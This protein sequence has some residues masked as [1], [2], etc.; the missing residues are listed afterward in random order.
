M[1]DWEACMTTIVIEKKFC[2]PPSSGNG[3][4]VAGVLAKTF[5]GHVSA[6]LRAPVPLGKPMSFSAQGGVATLKDGDTLIGDVAPAARDHLPAPPAAPTLEQARAAAARCGGSFHPICLTC[7]SKLSASEGLRVFVSQCAGAP[8]GQVAGL[9]NTHP[10]F[11]APDGLIAEEFVWAALD[12]P[13]FYAWVEMDG[14]H[15]A[16]LGTMQAEVLERP[17]VNGDYI[18]SAWPLEKSGRKAISGVAL[19]DREGRLMA[20]GRQIWIRMDGRAPRA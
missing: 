9:W 3:G 10:A 14:R 7:A 18:V 2:G 17:R 19:H 12:C 15:S 5:G 20:R 4:Y 6:A 16:L 8:R 11:A 13:G 1:R